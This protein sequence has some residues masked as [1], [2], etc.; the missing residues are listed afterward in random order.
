MKL[1]LEDKG[2]PCCSLLKTAKAFANG[3]PPL[4]DIQESS[5]TGLTK[6]VVACSLAAVA[7][8]CPA[9][10]LGPPG[11]V[12]LPLVDMEWKDG[13]GLKATALPLPL[14]LG[15]LAVGMGDKVACTAAGTFK[16]LS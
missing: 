3:M 11:D 12:L 10:V 6:T 14:P 5:F 1:F 7:L 2:L 16:S 4:T 8:V 9:E 13:V 15:V